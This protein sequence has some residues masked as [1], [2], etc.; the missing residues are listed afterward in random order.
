MGILKLTAP[1]AVSVCGVTSEEMQGEKG[2]A[3]SRD[4]HSGISAVRLKTS[5]SGGHRTFQ[6]EQYLFVP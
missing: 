5:G 2:F 4:E 6:N 3:R 1:S